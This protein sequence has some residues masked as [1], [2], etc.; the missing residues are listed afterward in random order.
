MSAIQDAL[1]LFGDG[2]AALETAIEG[3]TL[4]EMSYSPAPGKWN[5]RQIVRH[6]ADTEIVAGMRLRHI[7]AEDRPPLIPFNQDAWATNL[8]YANTDPAESLLTFRV[9]RNDTVKL[10]RSLP[11]EAFERTGV[12]PERGERSLL[13][14]VELFGRHAVAHA[15]QIRAIREAYPNK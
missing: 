4:E 14:F 12:H 15:A 11:A 7:V 10:L 1:A 13:A 5:I 9:L 6:V 8:N 3:T 2:P